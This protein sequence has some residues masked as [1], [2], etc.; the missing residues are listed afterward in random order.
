[1]CGVV[2]I[3]PPPN[4]RTGGK[5]G[6]RRDFPTFFLEIPRSPRA[7]REAY[8]GHSTVCA[9]ARQNSLAHL[10]IGS[11][12]QGFKFECVAQR[13]ISSSSACH[14]C[15]LR[16]LHLH[17]VPHFHSH[18]RMTLHI[19]KKVTTVKIPT[20]ALDSVKKSVAAWLQTDLLQE[21]QRISYF[22]EYCQLYDLARAAVV[23]EWRTQRFKTSPK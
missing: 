13:V 1:M 22:P 11:S 6:T 20:P 18:I 14:V 19:R 2:V 12:S 3:N 8:T 16:S 9:L 5:T 17:D 21:K 4:F 10:R 15:S 7:R 23:F